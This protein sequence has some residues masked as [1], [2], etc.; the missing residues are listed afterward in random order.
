MVDA[1][2]LK[3]AICWFESSLPHHNDR[4]SSL[5]FFCQTNQLTG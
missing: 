5:Y 3:S 2:D 4:A 1:A